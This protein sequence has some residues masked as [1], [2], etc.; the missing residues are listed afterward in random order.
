MAAEIEERTQY[1]WFNVAKIHENK[2]EFEKAL[3][4]YEEAIKLDESFAKAWYYKA[5]LLHQLGRMDEAKECA[6]KVLELEPK[7]E[8]HVREFLPEI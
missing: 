3:E 8:K 5:K 1:D 2:G 4:A 6:K 7:W